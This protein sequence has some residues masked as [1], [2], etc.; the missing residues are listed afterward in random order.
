MLQYLF[1]PL[2]IKSYIASWQG[3][4]LIN[5][6]IIVRMSQNS[7][8]QMCVCDMYIVQPITSMAM[9]INEIQ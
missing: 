2:K 1:N 6:L 4:I 3:Y 5:A 9:V 7:F 8:I